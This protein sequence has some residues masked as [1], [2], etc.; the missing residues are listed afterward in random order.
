MAARPFRVDV[1]GGS[2]AGELSGKGATT[3][4][5]VHG[6]GGSRRDWDGLVAHLPDDLAVARHDM[7]GF[8]E[9]QAEEGIAFSHADDLLALMD[10]LGVD[11]VALLG[12]SMGG[13]VALNFA[14]NHPERVSR[15]ILVSPAMVGW[16]WS[17][18]W[19]GEWRTVSKAAR[20]GDMDA[21]RALWFGH[22]MFAEVRKDEA[23]AAEL[24]AG[25]AAY[26]G[27]QWLRSDERP[28]LPDVDRL[29][30]L[31][32]PT[33]LLSGGRDVS[34][35]R[36]IADVIAGSAPDVR[37]VDYPDAGHMLHMERADEVAAEI[38]SF[39]AA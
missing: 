30:G 33:L 17:D 38:A 18:E 27:A 36:L 15:L 11:K 32:M 6:M 9:S 26:H 22:P 23:L 14:L 24:R 7:R 34:D 13:G 31:A 5:L 1:P 8:G 20:S 3:L 25:I 4:W 2:I 10:G 12:L 21:A 35:M 19:K 29:P 39:I 37:R 16:G 28:E